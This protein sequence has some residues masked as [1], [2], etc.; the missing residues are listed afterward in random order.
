MVSTRFGL[1]HK[2]HY[3]DSSLYSVA[4]TN[5]N[6]LQQLQNRIAEMELKANHDQLEARVRRRP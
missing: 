4:M 1:R 6:P 2:T 5:T 3:T